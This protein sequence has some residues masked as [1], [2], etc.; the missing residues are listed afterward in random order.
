MNGII[1]G[2]TS[3]STPAPKRKD[4]WS[5]LM[6]AVV[7]SNVAGLIVVY[8]SSQRPAPKPPKPYKGLNTAIPK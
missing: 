6:G 7:T 5:L 3:N 2:V 8:R 4:V 1:L